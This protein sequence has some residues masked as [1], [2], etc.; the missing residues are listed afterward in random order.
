MRFY[1]KCTTR[2]SN[3][4]RGCGITNGGCCHLAD[5][6]ACGR[7]GR[8]DSATCG[9]TN[10]SSNR[11]QCT[12]SRRVFAAYMALM[13]AHLSCLLHESAT[14]LLQRPIVATTSPRV[15][16][17]GYARIH[18]VGSVRSSCEGP[19]YFELGPARCL[20]TVACPSD[21]GRWGTGIVA[22]CR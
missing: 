5:V 6:S 15:L 17:L 16:E 8:P 7:H 3:A 21:G 18:R 4:A 22:L 1:T 2:R 20:P 9:C 10:I 11:T 19:C 14:W 13:A 12:Y